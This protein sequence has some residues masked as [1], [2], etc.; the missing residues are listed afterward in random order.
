MG[1]IAPVRPV[2]AATAW[3]VG[4]VESIEPASPTW[5]RPARM[6]VVVEEVLRGTPPP[7]LELA[8]GPPIGSGQSYF[9]VIRFL[10]PEPWAPEVQADVARQRA[11]LDATPVEAPEA[12]ARIAVGVTE[13][14][15]GHWSIRST[16]AQWVPEAGLAALRKA[17]AGHSM[18]DVDHR[19]FRARRGLALVVVGIVALVA[20]LGLGRRDIHPALFAVPALAIAMAIVGVLWIVRR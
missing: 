12:G 2:E 16:G 1:I 3:V 8:L 5:A 17:V 13:D 6:V 7:R 14:P 18:V 20:S 4:R 15:P 11:L 19:A 9:Y 10:G